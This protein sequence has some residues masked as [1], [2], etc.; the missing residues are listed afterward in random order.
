MVGLHSLLS[1]N[2][3]KYCHGIKKKGCGTHKMDYKTLNK[4][5]LNVW[6]CH[7]NITPKPNWILFT[8][9]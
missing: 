5:I 4:N 7:L 6:A 8:I 3:D 9:T 2:K 1:I